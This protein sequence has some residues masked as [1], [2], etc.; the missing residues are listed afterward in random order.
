MDLDLLV[1]LD[2][3]LTEGSVVGAAQRMH[4]SAPAMSRT[5]GRIRSA[6]GDPILVRAGRRLVPTPRALALQSRVRQVVEDARTLLQP[7]GPA[8]PSRIDRGFT[9]RASDYI[10][11]VFGARICAAISREAPRVVLRFAPQGEEDV[12]ALRDGRLDL[13][14]GVIGT[15]G[16]E[17]RVQALFRD[18]FV[19]VVRTGHPLTKGRVT[20]QRFSAVA[21]VGASRRGR[22]EGPIDQALAACGLA[23]RVAFV[24]PD[25]YAALFAA[26]GSDVAAAVP[27]HV[28]AG[29]RALGLGVAFFDLPVAVPAITVAQAWH[30]RYDNDA[31]HRWLRQTVR[32][33][34]IAVDADV[35]NFKRR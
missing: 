6:L 24:V 32:Q 30:P 25:F 5:L 16:P 28:A 20:A 1:A 18:R 14:I 31:G 8:D 9:V 12:S 17:I 4:L 27:K 7:A 11:G 3:L 26:A 2:A 33:T 35:R 21:H 29:A 22:S 34:I 13:E 15:T 23:R 19:G 10:A